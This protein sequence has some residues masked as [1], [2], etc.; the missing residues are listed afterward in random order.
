MAAN[1][2][3]TDQYLAA[4][5]RARREY[6]TGMAT[7]QGI[8]NG[9]LG[10]RMLVR[11]GRD[12][13]ADAAPERW[14]ETLRAT[15]YVP[16]TAAGLVRGSNVHG[17]APDDTTTGVCGRKVAASTLT[18][19][20]LADDHRRLLPLV[21]CPDCVQQLLDAFDPPG[22]HDDPI[23]CGYCGD[24]HPCQCD[25]ALRRAELLDGATRT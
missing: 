9:D 16:V 5:G 25:A 13:A 3:T 17:V 14:S 23:D 20:L 24:P 1:G 12:A 15:R 6:R 22:D 4:Y 8:V 11:A 10:T 18:T 21:T 7:W 19:T 2:P